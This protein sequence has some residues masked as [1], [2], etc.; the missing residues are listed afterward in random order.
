MEFT[1]VKATKRGKTTAVARKVTYKRKQVASFIREEGKLFIEYNN[2]VYP[3]DEDFIPIDNDEIY[4]CPSINNTFHKDNTAWHKVTVE[5]Y[6]SLNDKDRKLVRYNWD[7]FNL[8]L[9]IYAVDI[10]NGRATNIK[11]QIKSN[12]NERNKRNKRTSR[13]C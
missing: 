7:F 11:T 8:C 5:Y 1:I 3:I 2:A 10:V 12:E 13:S 6:T 9:S 4:L